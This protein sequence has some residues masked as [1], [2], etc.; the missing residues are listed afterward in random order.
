MAKP[1]A[2]VYK[3]LEQWPRVFVVCT[4]GEFSDELM[5]RFPAMATFRLQS[6]DILYH[7]S[8]YRA[9][10]D[11][12]RRLPG[13]VVG[14]PPAVLANALG[15]RA[16]RAGNKGA[17]L[18]YFEKAVATEGREKAETFLLAR[19]YAERGEYEA[20]LHLAGGYVRR[21]PYEA[22]PYTRMAEIY[23]KRGDRNSAIACYRRAVWLDHSKEKWRTRLAGL[24]MQRPFFGGISG[25]SDPRWM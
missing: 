11:L 7:D 24:V 2:G 21:H 5:T 4:D 10:G 3:T 18:R 19:L 1:R 17:A 25:Y 9:P 23:F 15:K 12:Y 6:L 20:A 22:W 14:V 8:S 16:L 13:D